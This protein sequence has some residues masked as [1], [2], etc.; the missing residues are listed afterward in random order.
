MSQHHMTVIFISLDELANCRWHHGDSNI[1]SLLVSF[2]LSTYKK[3]Q[4]LANQ[5]TFVQDRLLKYVGL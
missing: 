1:F 2:Q 4:F 3:F 5:N